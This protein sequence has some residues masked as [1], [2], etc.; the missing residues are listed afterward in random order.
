[1]HQE[2][3]ELVSSRT[4]GCV[5]R[6][7]A[8]FPSASGECVGRCST[9]TSDLG[10]NLAKP[11]NFSMDLRVGLCLFSYRGS[12]VR[13]LQWY[14][15]KAVNS[16]RC[17]GCARV[18]LGPFANSESHF[19]LYRTF[20]IMSRP[21]PLLTLVLGLQSGTKWCLKASCTSFHRPGCRHRQCWGMGLLVAQWA[22][23]RWL[24][25]HN[26][27]VTGS[28]SR[29]L[30]WK[31]HTNNPPNLW[32]VRIELWSSTRETRCHTTRLCYGWHYFHIL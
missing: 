4:W 9:S 8:W 10:E 30:K 23:L 6:C 27:Q 2:A 5:G 26:P 7:S 29:L 21:T 16:S 1:M 25:V 15:A 13:V 19:L 12:R 28:N 20:Q 22:R 3:R 14:S 24:K 32:L 11:S 18:R 31:I 17:L